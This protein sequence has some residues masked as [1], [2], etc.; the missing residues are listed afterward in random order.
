MENVVWIE[1]TVFAS[2]SFLFN[3]DEGVGQSPENGRGLS[4]SGTSTVF[5][6]STAT[7]SGEV[8]NIQTAGNL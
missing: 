7:P 4:V 2:S 8:G 1:N 6:G 3:K 5:D